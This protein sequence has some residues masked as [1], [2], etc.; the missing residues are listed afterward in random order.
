MQLCVGLYVPKTPACRKET[1]AVKAYLIVLLMT[2]T[3]AAFQYKLFTQKFLPQLLR[4]AASCSCNTHVESSDSKLLQ[5][6]VDA[7]GSEDSLL[8]VY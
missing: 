6:Q 7:C 8:L 4:K 2:S 1:L 3:E 5:Y